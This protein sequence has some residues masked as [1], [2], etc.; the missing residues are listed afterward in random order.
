MLAAG[1]GGTQEPPGMRLAFPPGHPGCREV[2]GRIQAASGRDTA[3]CGS[4]HGHFAGPR[5]NGRDV[6]LW[7]A[8]ARGPQGGRMEAAQAA[9]KQAAQAACLTPPRRLAV[10]VGKAGGGACLVEA[11]ARLLRVWSLLQATSAELNRD[12]P[13]AR[14]VP[15]LRS[16]LQAIRS[17]LED[18]VSPPLIAE[19]R[20]ALPPAEALSADELRIECAALLSWTATL[21]IQMLSTLTAARGAP[22]PGPPRAGSRD[23]SPWPAQTPVRS[24]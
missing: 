21:T 4:Q 22:P 8:V 10:I 20:H 24:R 19:L 15:R 1:P 5:G 13:P 12:P 6:R 17:D 16:Q 3:C 23:L 11:P 2:T 18:C 14:A 7:L 9:G